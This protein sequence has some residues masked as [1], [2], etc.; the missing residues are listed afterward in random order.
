MPASVS[1]PGLVTGT[2]IVAILVL[3]LAASLWV[4]V[5]ASSTALV[6]VSTAAWC[7]C[8]GVA[9]WFKRSWL[10]P[11]LC[12]VAMIALILLWVTVFGRVSWTSAFITMLGAMY[13]VAATIGALVGTWLGK[14]GV[15]PG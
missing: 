3:G 8:A 1:R 12:P 15:I 9:G 5:K 10:W 6:L 14:R 2:A 13:A 4:V 11:G 7:F